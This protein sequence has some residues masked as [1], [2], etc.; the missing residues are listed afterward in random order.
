MFRVAKKSI[1]EHTFRVL[2]RPARWSLQA[3]R[4]A[5]P[6]ITALDFIFRNTILRFNF[7]T[8]PKR[9][10]DDKYVM[11]RGLFYSVLR[12]DPSKKTLDVVSKSILMNYFGREQRKKFQEEHGLRPPSFFVISPFKGCNLRCSHCYA[13]SATEYD[14]L[15]YEIVAR[16]IYEAKEFW[17][18]RFV[19]IS[20]GEPFMY[21]SQRKGILDIAE[22]HNDCLF[23]VY[24]NG[25]LITEEVAHRMAEL[26]NI[27]PA[28]SVEGFRET[29][30]MRRGKGSF[31]RIL[32][33]MENLRR[34]G[35][36]FGLSLTATRQNAEEIVS[37]EFLDFFFEKKGASYAWLFHYMPI[38]RDVCADL[39]LTPEQRIRL[40]QRTWEIVREKKILFADF[41]NHGTVSNGCIAGGRPGGYF[42]IDWHGNVAPCVFF[43]YTAVNIKEIYERGGNLNDVLTTPFFRAIR[44]WQDSYGYASKGLNSKTD[45]LRPCPIRDH[46]EEARRI[47]DRY[48][49]KPIDEAAASALKNREYYKMMV[50]FDQALEK[51]TRKI[52]E[53]EY[54][55]KG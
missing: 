18:C 29:T 54:L 10:Q 25:T 46:Y 55:R 48:R 9:I 44:R 4:F 7:S 19:V 34:A 12:A 41:W 31:D 26:A 17:G 37:D 30:E 5:L 11:L 23:L 43:P 49:P 21:R 53:R 22:E 6:L 16:I 36:P 52:W 38:G 27:T 15:D 13:N 32:N 28:V 24:T 42:Y 50:D 8:F 3:G 14:K 45:W 35:V 47:I 51:T 1:Y 20:G 39:M 40:W 33:G 2:V